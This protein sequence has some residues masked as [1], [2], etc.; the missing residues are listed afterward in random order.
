MFPLI[1]TRKARRLGRRS[2]A[3]L[4]RSV[5]AALKAGQTATETAFRQADTAARAL[6]RSAQG[7]A[8]AAAPG[9]ASRRGARGR[10]VLVDGV[11]VHVIVRGRGRPV[12][13]IHGNGAMA[14]DFATCGLIDR[15]A[16]RYR[17]IAIDRPGFGRTDRP[18]NR[19]W[20]A[21]AQAALLNRVLERLKAERPLLVGHSW[22]TLVALAMAFEPGR[23]A[24]GLVLLSGYYFPEQRAD[25]SLAGPLALPGVGDAARALVPAPVNRALAVQAFHRVF[26]PQPVP[27]RFAAAFPV[28]IATGATQLRAATE[29]AATMNAAAGWLQGGYHRL[30]LPVAIVT[31]SADTIVNPAT[32]SMR[33]HQV[34]P[35][36]T[37]KVLPGQGHMIHYGARSAVERV[38]DAMMG[39]P[40]R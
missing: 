39:A 9:S 26:W 23:T 14:E 36:S 21:S 15:L 30:A 6:A 40:R 12:V 7:A 10:F 38:I 3:G 5:K 37:L 35:G 25:V 20:T 2:A 1:P 18:R 24:R 33:L 29:D 11:R 27:A 34:L 4:H 8:Q 19:I 28:E 17:V 16:E 13:L 32:Q 22:G 31:G